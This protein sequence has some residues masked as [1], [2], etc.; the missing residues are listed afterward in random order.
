MTTKKLYPVIGGRADGAWWSDTTDSAYRLIQP[1]DLALPQYFLAEHEPFPTP[2]ELL[3][4]DDNRPVPEQEFDVRV[5]GEFETPSHYA[6]LPI[7]PQE[8]CRYLPFNLGNVV[9]YA[10]RCGKKEGE[11]AVKDLR[12]AAVYLEDEIERLIELGEEE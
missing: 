6:W 1:V 5:E 8:I 7:Q 12:K 4:R 10:C 2:P 11:S 9:K 3:D